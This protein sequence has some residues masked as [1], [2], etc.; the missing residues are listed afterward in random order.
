MR[1]L[2]ILTVLMSMVAP[3]VPVWGA[4]TAPA[5]S[6]EVDLA[7][8]LADPPDFA[9]KLDARI[10]EFREAVEAA[11]SPVAR[12]AA[13]LAAA[14]WLIGTATS[15]PA[16]RWLVGMERPDDPAHLAAKAKQA[17][18]HLDKARAALKSAGQDK[19]PSSKKIAELR[20]AA[21]S[22]EP[23]V[24]V[25]AAAGLG[26]DADK[27]KAAFAEAALGLAVTRESD[28]PELSACALL[29]QSLAWEHAGRRERAMVSLPTALVRPGQP[30]FDF[31][32]RLLRCRLA[33]EEGRCAAAFALARRV[34]AECDLWF[35][36]EP[37]D[38][39]AARRRL[40]AA[41]QYRIGQ[42]WLGQLAKSNSKSATDDVKAMLV[43]L[44]DVLYDKNTPGAV[45]VPESVVPILVQ[46][47]QVSTTAPT[48]QSPTRPATSTASTE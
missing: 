35:P 5:A 47:S 6:G 46:P 31:L 45:Y 13:H 9:G 48:T 36:K 2:T 41:T 37:P 17:R 10:T 43:G 28:N 25:F 4:E 40:A 12:A 33:A 7:A 42:A 21:D 27:R 16:V 8:C 15:R 22:L 18:E 32:A 3:A 44:R 1:N 38:Q 11:D 26:G 39:L 24:E 30:A 20:L 14:N 23:F 34:R 29:W 19:S